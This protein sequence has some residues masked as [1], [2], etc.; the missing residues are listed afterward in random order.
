LF[1]TFFRPLS[2][3][4]GLFPEPL[5]QSSFIPP[6]GPPPPFSTEHSA[7]L[8]HRHALFPYTVEQVLSLYPREPVSREGGFS[9]ES[10]IPSHAFSLRFQSVVTPP[11]IGWFPLCPR[12]SSVFYPSPQPPLLSQ[13]LQA[14]CSFSACRCSL[15]AHFSPLTLLEVALIFSSSQV[16]ASALSSRGC[17]SRFSTSKN[18]LVLE[19]PFP[20][21][22]LLS[23]PSA[24][25]L[26]VSEQ[27]LPMFFLFLQRRG[28][29]LFLHSRHIF[30]SINSSSYPKSR[31]PRDFSSFS[32]RLPRPAAVS[33][34]VLKVSTSVPCN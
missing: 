6:G 29:P 12:S 7:A 23:S 1:S 27:S 14:F 15:R 30:F 31:Q 18:P 32:S 11:R 26:V 28:H 5:S 8:A 33:F 4:V 22:C 21:S 2:L 17:V 10:P 13:H 25:R 9:A 19:S 24:P 3:S 16:V 34:F 20:E